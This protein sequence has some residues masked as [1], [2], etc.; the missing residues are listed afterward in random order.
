MFSIGNVLTS[1]F[2]VKLDIFHCS[3]LLP[4]LLGLESVSWQPEQASANH[5]LLRGPIK[6]RITR[7]GGEEIYSM[8]PQWQEEKIK[9][10]SDPTFLN[11]KTIFCHKV[12][13]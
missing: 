5:L 10:S 3:M 12:K 6:Q 1:W 9:I 2:L 13:V 7:G 8:Q 11:P 4:E